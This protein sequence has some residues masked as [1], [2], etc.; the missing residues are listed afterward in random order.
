M[1]DID[2]TIIGAGIVGLA[3]ASSLSK[4][5]ENIVVIERHDGF[6]RETSS[7]NSEVIHA[8]I[9]YTEGSLKAKLCVAGKNMIYEI[10]EK[11]NIRHK[12]LGKFIVV[13]NESE[14][15]ILEALKKNGEKNG[16]NDLVFYESRD[17]KKLEPHINA[18]LAIYSPSTGIIDTHNLMKYFEY[19]AQSN[20]TIIVYNSELI[21]IN[22]ESS[23]YNYKVKN[24]DGTVDSFFTRILINSGGLHSDKIAEMA[25]M[26][27]D[28]ANYRLHYCKGDYMSWN[29]SA[30]LK[31]LIYPLPSKYSI[32]IHACIDLNGYIK[33]GP[34]AYFINEIN[35]D[36]V[37]KKEE[38]YNS[39][40]TYLPDIELDDLSPAMSGIRPKLQSQ[41]VEFRDFVICHEYERGLDGLI[42]LIGIESPGLTASPAIAEYVKEIVEQIIG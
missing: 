2:I 10:C 23:G 34:N 3:I 5:Y 36:V 1:S 11:N 30:V 13:D 21:K 27:I 42:N 19:E 32:G 8:G 6:G 17:I 29:K 40:K 12:R 35:Y 7:R 28:E 38:F 20:G 24:V 16:V 18:K 25:G 41:A 39:I 22:K 14:I 33:F 31:H 9:Y 4:K 26:N 15:S 37:S